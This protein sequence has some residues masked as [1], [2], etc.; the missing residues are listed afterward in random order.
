[1]ESVLEPRGLHRPRTGIQD[2]A[3]S[4][5]WNPEMLPCAICP[6]AQDIPGAQTRE[7]KGA[8]LVLLLS[9]VGV[10]LDTDGL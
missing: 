1:M 7:M 4:W 8:G 5:D 2:H 10:T 6:F 3:W 9:Q